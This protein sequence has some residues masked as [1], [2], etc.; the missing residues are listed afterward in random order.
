MK[1]VKNRKPKSRQIMMNITSPIFIVGAPR[2]GTT[3]LQKMLLC[4]DRICGGQESHFF[5]QIG[6]VIGSYCKWEAKSRKVG[7]P[8]YWDYIELIDEIRELWIKTVSPLANQYPDAK[9]Y[10]EKT[11]RHALHML[12]IK[13]TLPHARFIYIIRDSRSVVSSLLAA[14]KDGWGRDWASPDAE[15]GAKLWVEYVKSASEQFAKM[16]ESDWMWIHYEDLFSDKYNELKKIYRYIFRNEKEDLPDMILEENTSQKWVEPD[17]FAR[18]RGTHGWK[19]DL[20][21]KQKLG[22]WWVTRNEMRLLGYSKE[23]RIASKPPDWSALW[24][25]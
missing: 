7:L 22:V 11:P 15:S 1:N 25:R 17:R 21:L 16:H 13:E 6:H 5:S 20:S 14:R 23:G 18:I 3:W 4:D 12:S 2:S 10:L 9:V 24:K 8:C 19:N